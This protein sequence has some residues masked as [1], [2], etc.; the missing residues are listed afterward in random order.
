MKRKGFTLLE[1]FAIIATIGVLIA[2]ILP[3]YKMYKV[4]KERQRTEEKA[5]IE[6][7]ERAR[8]NAVTG[9]HTN[10]PVTSITNK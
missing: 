8:T 2:L 1:L 5:K 7:A 6:A 4:K 9:L 10:L 3:V